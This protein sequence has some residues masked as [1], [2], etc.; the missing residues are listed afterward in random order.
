MWCK[1]DNGNG[2]LRAWGG[3]EVGGARLEGAGGGLFIGKGALWCGGHAKTLVA[4]ARWWRAVVRSWA[5]RGSW[6]RHQM[7]RSTEK[8]GR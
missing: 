7:G 6:A 8:L 2:S 1:E 3:G 4:V 5:G